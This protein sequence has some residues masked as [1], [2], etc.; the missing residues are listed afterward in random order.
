[1]ILSSLPKII[2]FRGR[3]FFLSNMYPCKVKL[4]S[5]TFSS[6]EHA[7]QAAKCVNREDVEKILRC[8]TGKEAKRVGRKVK[9]R[10]DWEKIKDGV[11][12]E[13]IK[14]KFTQNK[15]LAEKLIATYP[16]ILVEGNTWRDTYWGVDLFDKGK[17]YQYGY[18]GRNRLG[19]ILMEVR[20]ELRK[21]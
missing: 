17:E 15:H 13:V 18:R 10:E 8:K 3:Y 6:A 5:V 1:M 14:A 2:R 7:F 4:N 16:T 19:E 11:M 21:L 12:Y 9:L 20:E